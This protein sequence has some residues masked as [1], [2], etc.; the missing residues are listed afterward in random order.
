LLTRCSCAAK[1]KSSKALR[2]DSKLFDQ[3]EGSWIYTTDEITTKLILSINTKTFTVESDRSF[4]HHE[5]TADNLDIYVP[6]NL[7]QRRA[8]YRSQLPELLRD[9]LGVGPAATFNIS[10]IVTSD[11][12]DLEDILIEQDIPPVEWI[13]KPVLV[14]PDPVGNET[15]STSASNVD[16]SNSVTLMTPR[17]E[18][19]T[20]QGSP[21]QQSRREVSVTSDVE[22]TPP[23]QYPEFIEQVV[24]SAQRAGYRHRDAQVPVANAPP[25]DN[26]ERYFN[27]LETFGRRDENAFVHDRRIGA[28]G[29]AF[30]CSTSR[31]PT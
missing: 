6:A 11:L 24:R 7:K 22:A 23:E 26:E 19:V 3:L 28:A 2:N 25:D 21:T 1:Y 31:D 30:V 10:S 29:E 9:L 13:Q 27:H 18:I 16:G 17:S 15:L 5:F 14:I 4:I 8:C 12:E 20:P